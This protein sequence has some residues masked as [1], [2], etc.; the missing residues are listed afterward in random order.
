MA[1]RIILILFIIPLLLSA[2]RVRF[3]IKEHKEVYKLH[4]MGISVEELK[5]GWVVV[6]ANDNQI[7]MLKEQG[8][9]LFPYIEPSYR[10]EEYHSYQQMVSKLDSLASEYPNIAKKISIGQ[11]VQG[12]ELWVLKLSDNPLIDEAEP[13]IRFIGIIHGDEPIGCELL[14]R[15]ADTLTE[16]YADNGYFTEL[17][18]N[19]EIFIMPMLNPDGRESGSRYNANYEDLNRDF[20]VPDSSIGGDGNWEYEVETQSLIDWSDTM[21]F[22]LSVTYH[23]GARVVNYQWDYTHDIP[24]FHHLI[25]D[26]SKGYAL[27]NDSMF[28]D[29]DPWYAD[30]GVIRGSE[31]YVISGSVQDWAF[32][33]TDCIDLTVELNSQKWPSYTKLPEL[34]R[35][36][37]NSLLYLI[38][39]AGTG[40]RGFVTDGQTGNPLP[41][42]IMVDGYGKGTT[43]DPDVGDYHLLLRTGTYNLIF[44]SEGYDSLTINDITVNGDSILT[45]N[46]QLNA[47][48]TTA[49]ELPTILSI[50]SIG[51]TDGGSH[52]I[53]LLIPETDIFTLSIFDLTGR[54][55][56]IRFRDR[57]LSPGTHQEYIPS[58]ALPQGIYFLRLKPKKSNPVTRK[59]I[60]LH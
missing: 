56:G 24:P 42:S 27:R 31:W 19:R 2:S 30:S 21:N 8:Y 59:I 17:L 28:Y 16:C 20:P 9:T 48:G 58:S 29:P 4:E 1:K 53:D 44:A 33:Y 47:A 41:T 46:V 18:N 7:R 11:S 5:D 12:R 36:N 13:E 49:T 3:R 60:V 6:R 38:Q 55:I 35:Q 10:T 26:I 37:K 52:R 14:L 43:T 23:S 32:H 25:R 57:L 22:N 51:V 39:K 50:E 34:W 45:L 15:L 40:V 54:R